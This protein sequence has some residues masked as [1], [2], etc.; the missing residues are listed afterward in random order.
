MQPLVYCIRSYYCILA[1]LIA[2][3]NTTSGFSQSNKYHFS[4]SKMGSPFNI[5]LWEKDSITAQKHADACFKLIDSLN[6]IFSNY[7]TTS[8]LSH[9]N[10]QAGVRASQASPLMWELI[11]LSKNAYDESEGSFNFALGPITYLWRKARH[12]K[13]F[14]TQFQVQEKLKLCQFKNIQWNAIQH[15]IYLP[16]QG[17]QLDFGGIGKG[18]IAQK[19]IQLLRQRGITMALADA[20]GDIVVS[21]SPVNEKG[22]KIGINIPEQA[23]ELLP[24]VL[25]IKNISVATSGD[26]YQFMENKGIK[27]SHIIDPNTGYGVTSLRNVTVIAKDGATA[28]WL[29]TACSILPISKA[30]KVAQSQK[31]ELLITTLYQGKVRR[32]ATKGFD[33]Y[34]K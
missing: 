3:L 11:E 10:Q 25:R 14:P 28:D 20:G 31:A 9:I 13:V 22:W 18:Y 21:D 27:Y 19:V 6:H 29:A 5:V 7:D 4:A 23:E 8:E 2:I 30:K 1:F 12:E 33:T 34:F 26:V 17:M 32:Y 15:S 24:T 16:Q